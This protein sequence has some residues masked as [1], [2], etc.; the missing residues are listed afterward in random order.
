M[1]NKKMIFP[2]IMV[3]LIVIYIIAALFIAPFP[4]T[5]AQTEKIAIPNSTSS[6]IIW[7]QYG[8]E[9]LGV[10]GYGILATNGPQV[11]KPIG[12]IAKLVLALSITQK[13]PLK[14]GEQGPIITISQADLDLFNKYMAE[15]GSV[16]PVRLN[17]KLSEYQALQ[18]LL[19]PSGDNIADTIA[20]W[21]FG[22]ID[23]YLSF[24]NERLSSWNLTKTHVA[25]ASGLSAQTVSNPGD[26]IL[27]G[28]QVLK[29][30]VLAD[31]VSQSQANLPVIG[32]AKN[33][34]TLL[35]ANN[36]IGIKTGNTAE[37]GGCFLFAQKNTINGQNITEIV[38]ILGATNLSAVL[39]GARNFLQNNTQI[40]QFAT[41]VHAGQKVG[42]YKLPWGTEVNVVAQKDLSILVVNGQ[43]VTINVSLNKINRPLGK[44]ANVGT[45]TAHSGSTSQSVP[46]VLE[47]QISSPSV[48]WKLA[49]F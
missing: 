42:S 47:T 15:N 21:G 37:A 12:S 6:A 8:S 3:L 33:Y 43:S 2:I 20:I 10:S 44:G 35:G 38:S 31:I 28:D 27:L 39:A 1:K 32:I 19:L 48:F 29:V 14:S 18:A 17:E 41:V 25:D 49:H 16:V 9:A 26:L 45:I 13:K 23:N 7:P 24:A 22:T 30:P 11:S 40:F 36:V 46:A 34:N 4:K 5:D